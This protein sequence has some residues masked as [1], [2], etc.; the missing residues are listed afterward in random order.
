MGDKLDEEV[1]MRIFGSQL[2]HPALNWYH[3]NIQSI[4]SW[5]ELIALFGKR[6][7]P[8]SYDHVLYHDLMNFK[9]NQMPMEEYAEQFARMVE[10]SGDPKAVLEMAAVIFYQNI[11]GT[12]RMWMD[13]K[14]SDINKKSFYEVM[15]LARMTTPWFISPL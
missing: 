1:K 14:S 13:T 4:S 11:N 2:R 5:A 15:A 10:S 9:Q 3:T 12:I 7:Y 8:D 6:Y